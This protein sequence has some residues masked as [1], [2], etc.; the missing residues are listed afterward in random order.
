MGPVHF[1]KKGSNG[2]RLRV[3]NP[4]L[5]TPFCG[6]LSEAGSEIC[7]WVGSPWEVLLPLRAPIL[8]APSFQG[9]FV[10]NAPAWL[11]WKVLLC[12]MLAWT[13]IGV[14]QTV[15]LVNRVL[16]P[17][18]RGCFDKNGEN[19]EFAFYP[20]KTRASLLRP[21]KMTK[22]ASVTQA[23]AWFRKSRVCSS[24]KL[25]RSD[26]KRKW[27]THPPS[28]L[29]PFAACWGIWPRRR[30]EAKIGEEKST[31]VAETMQGIQWMKTLVRT[32]SYR[33]GDNSVKRSGAMWWIAM[34]WELNLLPS[35]PFQR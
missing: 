24:L 1:H 15:F 22:M 10:G 29:P 12:K 20:L 25:P 13:I 26:R 7:F 35:F 2:K 28:G 23:K 31:S 6:T 19:D 14:A 33:G 21:P 34:P 32:T 11:L 30:D 3:A 9:C 4:L 17:A 8:F 5:P 18:K 27:V 16:S